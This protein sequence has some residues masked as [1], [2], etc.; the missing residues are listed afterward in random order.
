MKLDEFISDPC[1]RRQLAKALAR[2]PD[3][4]W[5]VAVSWR[6]R[7]PSAELAIAIERETEVI[8][9]TRVERGSLRPD[10]WALPA[11][12]QAEKH[13]N[14]VS[15]SVHSEGPKRH[16]AHDRQCSDGPHAADAGTTRV[17]SA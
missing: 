13:G 10:L 5:Q 14:H 6:G 3:Y 7:R 4:L 9:P 17:G 16:E 11:E 8:G 15:G 12:G 1:R 2:S